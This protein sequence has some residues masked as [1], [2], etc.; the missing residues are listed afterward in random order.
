MSTAV[1][2][3]TLLAPFEVKSVDTIA[4]TFDGLAATWDLDLGGDVIHRG[5]FKDTLAEWRKSGKALPLIDQHNY[6]SVRAVV[7]KMLDAK[8]TKDGLDAQFEVIDGP[9]GDEVLRRLKGGYVDGLSIGY[10]PKL[11]EEPSDDE[12]RKGIWRHLKTVRLREVSVVIW[13]MNPG[14]TVDTSSVKMMAALRA[15][16]VTA[17][18]DV[19]DLETVLHELESTAGSV[20]TMIE[21][22]KAVAAA[23]NAPPD[24]L[25]APDTSLLD[26]LRLLRIRPHHHTTQ[27][28]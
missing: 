4:R 15:S 24:D 1:Q 5:A 14:A 27:E 6:G 9:D 3:K 22:A 11:V 8:E 16:L 2:G 23:A 25:N 26:R 20:R 18:G 10:E 17:G 13:P 28:T 12:R 19:D 7:G 21:D